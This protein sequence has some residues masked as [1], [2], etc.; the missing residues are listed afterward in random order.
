LVDAA[1]GEGKGAL[2]ARFVVVKAGKVVYDKELRAEAK[3][4]SSFVGA[5]AIP[6][7]V[8]EYTTLH[9]QLV[10]KLLDDP[11]FRVAVK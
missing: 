5:V 7:A 3:W 4:E 11:Q 1:I 10:T 8:N 9:R 2:A 6:R